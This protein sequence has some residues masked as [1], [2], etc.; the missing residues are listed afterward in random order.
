MATNTS[1]RLRVH[2]SPPGANTDY[3]GVRG[4][5][6]SHVDDIGWYVAS[7]VAVGLGAPRPD[8]ARAVR[9]CL[10]N[11]HQPDVWGCGVA[12]LPSHRKVDPG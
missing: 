3:P 8:G 2:G 11:S 1:R 12:G 6:P 10:G 9:N 4:Y 5:G 7:R